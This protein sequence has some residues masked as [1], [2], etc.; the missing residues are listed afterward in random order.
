MRITALCRRAVCA[1]HR[2]AERRKTMTR[3]HILYTVLSSMAISAVIVI[4]S[5]AYSVKSQ[6]AE[7]YRKSVENSVVETQEEIGYTLKEY[8]GE[9]AVFRGSSETPYRLLGVSTAVMSEYDRDLLKDGIFVRTEGELDR[10]IEDF[11]P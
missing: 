11:T 3:R 2:A 9:L 5:L 7:A 1:E 6:R 4:V 8:N 10:L